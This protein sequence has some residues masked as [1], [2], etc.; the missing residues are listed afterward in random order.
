MVESALAAVRPPSGGCPARTGPREGAA[1]AAAAGRPGAVSRA[2]GAPAPPGL[3]RRWVVSRA[4]GAAAPPGAGWRCAVS[5]AAAAA[6]VRLSKDAGVSTREMASSSVESSAGVTCTI[7]VSGACV[8]SSGRSKTSR[9]VRLSTRSTVLTLG[10]SV[11]WVNAKSWTV[12]VSL[13]VTR[14][15]SNASRGSRRRLPSWSTTP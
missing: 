4:P 1:A 11:S 15:V 10:P 3:G 2:A 12:A 8:G 9:M 13:R 7:D 5:R 6:L 14:A